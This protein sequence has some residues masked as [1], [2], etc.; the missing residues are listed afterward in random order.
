MK[1]HEQHQKQKRPGSDARKTAFLGE[2]S[3]LLITCFFCCHK[4]HPQEQTAGSPEKYGGGPLEKENSYWKFTIFS[5][6]PK[7]PD[8]SIQCLVWEP[9]NTPAKNRF[10]QTPPLEGPTGEM[11]GL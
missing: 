11:L 3:S 7:Y 5:F 10:K 8:P 2:K 9:Q 6:F 1:G 4:L